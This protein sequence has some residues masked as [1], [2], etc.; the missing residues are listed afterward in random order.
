M[1]TT[2]NKGYSVLFNEITDVSEE[3]IQLTEN[4]T[5][6]VNQ[7]MHV[8]QRTEEMFIE[9]DEIEGIGSISDIQD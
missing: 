9:G 8:Q 7:L 1:K 6:I 4:L 5:Q 2:I 3:L